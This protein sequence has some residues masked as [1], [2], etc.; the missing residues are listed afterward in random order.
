MRASDSYPD[1]YRKL[2]EVILEAARESTPPKVFGGR[3]APW[4]NQQIREGHKQAEEG[5]EYECRSVGG[6]VSGAGHHD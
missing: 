4:D 3:R 5:H 1:K 6:E 2:E